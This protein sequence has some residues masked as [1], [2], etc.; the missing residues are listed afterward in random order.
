MSVLFKILAVFTP[1][2][3]ADARDI[4]HSYQMYQNLVVKIKDAYLRTFLEEAYKI[5]D[6]LQNHWDTIGV[7]NKS[8]FATKRGGS[9]KTWKIRWFTLKGHELKYYEEPAADKPLATLDLKNCKKVYSDSTQEKEHCIAMEFK[10]RTYFVYFTSINEKN[11]WMNAI[12]WKVFM[13]KDPVRRAQQSIHSIKIGAFPS[14]I[15][16]IT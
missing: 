14:T 3:S 15:S 6:D 5:C 10:E 8:G 16:L 7:S 2:T 1:H 9:V 13:Q 12:Q 4:I 11:E